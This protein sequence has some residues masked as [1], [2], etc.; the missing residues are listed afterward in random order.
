VAGFKLARRSDG[1]VVLIKAAQRVVTNIFSVGF[2][3]AQALD[4]VFLIKLLAIFGT[5]NIALLF[6]VVTE[7][8]RLTRV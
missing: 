1:Y 8:R 4:S 6:Y 5:A 7:F 2:L 3:Y